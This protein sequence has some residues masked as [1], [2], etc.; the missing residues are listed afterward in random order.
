MP[1]LLPPWLP[2]AEG[3]LEPVFPPPLSLEVGGSPPL[4]AP[5]LLVDGADEPVG[6]IVEGIWQAAST[7]LR[8]AMALQ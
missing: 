1:P 5:P 7:K 8:N 4:E 6:G 2:S 3:A